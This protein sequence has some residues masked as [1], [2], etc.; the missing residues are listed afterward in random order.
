MFDRLHTQW[1][2][3]KASRPGHRFRDRYERHRNSNN[4]PKTVWRIVRIV[5]ALALIAIAVV[6][7]FIPGPAVVFYFFAGALLATDSLPVARLLDWTEVQARRIGAK[8]RR[9]WRRLPTV[10]RI[11]VAALGVGL[12][13]TGTLLFYRFVAH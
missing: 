13:A 11:A 7:M 12:S 2:Q 3:L 10:G 1:R 6:F 8:G 4:A 9:E 5:I